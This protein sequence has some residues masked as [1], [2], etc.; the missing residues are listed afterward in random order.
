MPLSNDVKLQEIAITTQNY[1]GAD[2]AA[3][4]REAA[5]NAM[6]NKSSKI[7]SHDFCNEFETSETI[8]YQ[9]SGSMV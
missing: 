2:L 6:T 5:V 8:N 3:L 4:C 9:R 7:T 1:T